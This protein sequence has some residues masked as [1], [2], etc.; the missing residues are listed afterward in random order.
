MSNSTRFINTLQ[1]LSGNM[2]QMSLSGF[3]KA[4]SMPVLMKNTAPLLYRATVLILT[5]GI[6]ITVSR[7][8]AYKDTSLKVV[9]IINQ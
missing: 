1:I 4:G 6:I 9:F 8:P 5:F 2:I 7:Y 3:I